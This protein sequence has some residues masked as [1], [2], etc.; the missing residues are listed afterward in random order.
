MLF[1]K[2]EKKNQPNERVINL[3]AR[4]DALRQADEATRSRSYTLDHFL[5]G[6]DVLTGREVVDQYTPSGFHAEGDPPPA[7]SNQHEVD[8]E[9][10]LQKY[11][12]RQEEQTERDPAP[13]APRPVQ[14][15]ARERGSL[16]PDS[17]DEFAPPPASQPIAEEP[18]PAEDT[19]SPGDGIANAARSAGPERPWPDSKA[20]PSEEEWPPRD[21]RVV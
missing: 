3:K 9:A 13:E 20:W 10:E 4:V 7:P 15:P 1:G 19:S 14:P 11:L 21:E 5:E 6:D 2:R 8:L 18:S 12:L 17:R 16:V